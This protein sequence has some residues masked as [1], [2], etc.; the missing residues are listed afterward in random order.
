MASVD[1]RGQGRGPSGFTPAVHGPGPRPTTSRVSS[2]PTAEGTAFGAAVGGAVAL[3]AASRKSLW[4][5]IAVGAG[6]VL[7]GGAIGLET[8]GVARDVTAGG[9]VGGAAALLLQVSGLLKPTQG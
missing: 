8:H 5:R 6:A 1:R 7:V 3:W 4:G 9:A 2:I